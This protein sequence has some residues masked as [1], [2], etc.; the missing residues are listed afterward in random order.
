MKYTITPSDD[1]TFLVM[2]AHCDFTIDV[3]RKWSVEIAAMGRQMNIRRFLFDVRAARNACT[4]ADNYDAAYRDPDELDLPKDIRSAI[5][6]SEGDHSHDFVETTYLNA[7]YDVRLFVDESAAI[8]WL[9]G[10]D[11]R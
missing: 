9:C 8:N 3:A 11:D 10:S 6:V 7:G 4:V 1:G 2:R 5:L